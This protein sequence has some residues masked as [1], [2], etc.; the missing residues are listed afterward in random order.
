M[1]GRTNLI[2]TIWLPQLLYT[3]HN[4]PVW[5][6]R[7]WFLKISS[8]FRELIWKKGQARIS[9]QTLQGPTSKGGMAALHPYSYYL[10]AQL[11]HIGGCDSPGEMH[12][13]NKI[14]LEGNPHK[15]LVEAL[16][17]G[18]LQRTLPTHKLVI[19]TWQAVKKTMGY[20]GITM[21]SP[22]WHNK[23]LQELLTVEKND[24]W[25][26]HG[27][28]RLAHLVRDNNVKSFLDLRTEYE[29][30]YNTFYS[31]LQI[32]H[33]L[34]VQ[35]RTCP[36]ELCRAPLLNKIVK[37][38]T[39]KGLIAAVYVQLVDKMITTQTAS[40]IRERWEAYVGELTDCQW[41]RILEHGPKVSVA[42]GLAPLPAT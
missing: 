5:I 10:A 15:S 31:Y 18:T 3:L 13:S 34:G 16:E 24:I 1:A 41:K 40:G 22:I 7:K 21:F 39:T 12:A 23:F 32:R 17:A 11:Q 27:I 8:L 37:V 38:K 19:K 35:F 20:K 2:R 28:T 30:P 4:S 42:E 26:R 36:M 29:V 6:G 25:E 9:L 14:M 33:A